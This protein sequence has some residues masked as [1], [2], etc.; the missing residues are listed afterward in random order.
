M[1][2]GWKSEMCILLR[3]LLDDF[4]EPYK[5]KD[6]SIQR[7]IV[8]AAQYVI[9]ELTFPVK[10]EA[11]INSLSI[12]PDPTDDGGG[13]HGGNG[14]GLGSKT[15]DENFINL[16]CLKAACIA[17]MGAARTAARQSFLMK[18]GTTSV[19]L[20]DVGKA[21]LELIKTGF[22][23]LYEQ[24]KMEYVFGKNGTIAGGAIV[25]PFKLYAGYNGRHGSYF[26]NRNDWF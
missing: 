20:R 4:E 12:T 25:T 14:E 11:D 23:K 19:D 3:V 22:C 6:K 26:A 18:D 2:S 9:A 17:D 7:L 10:Y 5:I 21:R 24:A 1:S 8:A 15:R 16:T 13:S